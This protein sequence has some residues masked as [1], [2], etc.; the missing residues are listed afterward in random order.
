M[1]PAVFIALMPVWF[2]VVA[3]AFFL[4][5]G[6]KMVARERKDRLAREAA[7]KA[8]RAAEQKHLIEEVLRLSAAA[9]NK[10]Q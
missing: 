8:E 4:T 3:W 9:Q 1:R 7:R 2:A 5:F 10:P 6:R